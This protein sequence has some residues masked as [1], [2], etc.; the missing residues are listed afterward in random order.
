MTLELAQVLPDV[1]VRE[2]LMGQGIGSGN[3]DGHVV[4][5]HRSSTGN[6]ALVGI[7]SSMMHMLPMVPVETFDTP[8]SGSGRPLNRLDKSS[9]PQRYL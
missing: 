6:T 2:R 3:L 7:R 5:S 4:E 1:L 9:S 8:S